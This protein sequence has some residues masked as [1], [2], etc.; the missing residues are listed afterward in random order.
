MAVVWNAEIRRGVVRWRRRGK[1]HLVD[2]MCRCLVGRQVVWEVEK[3]W[4]RSWG[5]LVASHGASHVR[6][7]SCCCLGM[8]VGYVGTGHDVLIIP[9][10]ALNPMCSHYSSSM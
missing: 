6:L 7:L 5:W 4:R 8:W 10:V 2:V 3:R 1:L 9:R